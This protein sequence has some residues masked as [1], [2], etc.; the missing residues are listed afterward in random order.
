MAATTRS[1]SPELLTSRM[2]AEVFQAYTECSQEIQEAIRDMIEIVNDSSATEDEKLMACATIS[3]ALFPSRSAGQLGVDLED[4]E[5]LD[6]ERLKEFQEVH[7]V[8]E[9]EEAHFVD[10]VQFLMHERD[11]T[12]GQLAEA[13]GIGQPGVSNLLSR[14]SR[15][16]RRTIDKIAK[17]L[18]VS[19]HEIW[20]EVD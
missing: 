14:R 8:M 2:F 12:Q 4:A 1:R 6:S 15:P 7:A 16:Q 18:N 17:A 3:E 9:H 19:P 11:M 10:R 13:C 5:H 20:P